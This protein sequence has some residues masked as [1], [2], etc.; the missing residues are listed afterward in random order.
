MGV[1]VGAMSSIEAMDDCAVEMDVE[2]TGVMLA[3]AATAAA[4]RAAV[5]AEVAV[6]TAAAGSSDA[7]HEAAVVLDWDEL[8]S[9]LSGPPREGQADS[10]VE[11]SPGGRALVPS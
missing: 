5:P 11:K 7:D 2:T 9:G 10:A 4:E 1:D 3:A 6:V 8:L